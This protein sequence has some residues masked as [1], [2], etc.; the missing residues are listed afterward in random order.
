MS[1]TA[2]ANLNKLL[3]SGRDSAL[4]RFSL[5]SEYLKNDDAVSA[6]EHLRVAVVL[7]ATYS[8]AWKALGRALESMSSSAE[9]LAVFKEGIAVAERNGDKQAAREMSVFARRIERRLNDRS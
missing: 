6:A 8:A 4:L 1:S 9:A 2:L 5:G 7:D 3:A